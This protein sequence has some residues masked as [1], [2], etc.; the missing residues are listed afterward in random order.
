MLHI[1]IILRKRPRNHTMLYSLIS[2]DLCPLLVTMALVILL[3]SLTPSL[4]KVRSISSSTGPKCLQCTAGIKHSRSGL[5]KAKSYVDYMLMGEENI[6]VTT[7]NMTS[8]RKVQS[9]HTQYQQVNN[10]MVLLNA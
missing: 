5:R 7:S 8:R 3:V 4:K 1:R 9:S 10:K 2:K 6:W